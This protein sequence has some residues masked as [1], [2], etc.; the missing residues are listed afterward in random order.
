MSGPLNAEAIFLGKICF[1][2]F[3]K[4]RWFNQSIVLTKGVK[5]WWPIYVYNSVVNTKLPAKFSIGLNP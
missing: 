4:L 1:S 2:N 3:K 5:A